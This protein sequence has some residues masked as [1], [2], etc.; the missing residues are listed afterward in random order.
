MAKK[1]EL[2]SEEL[3]K[4]SGGKPNLIEPNTNVDDIPLMVETVTTDKIPAMAD[5]KSDSDN[6]GNFRVPMVST[7]EQTQLK[8]FFSKIAEIFRKLFN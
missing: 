6:D 8:D 5:L 4:V 1:K 3:N 2:N 7:A